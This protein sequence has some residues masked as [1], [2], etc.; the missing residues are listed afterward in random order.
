MPFGERGVRIPCFGSAWEKLIIKSHLIIDN[1]N[2]STSP[3]VANLPG[4][5]VGGAL[6]PKMLESLPVPE[7]N[8]SNVR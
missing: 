5:K 2:K 4:S 3:R 6:C 7:E 8:C 1:V